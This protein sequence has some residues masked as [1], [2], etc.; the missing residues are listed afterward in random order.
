MAPR[1]ILNRCIGH[2]IRHLEHVLVVDYLKLLRYRLRCHWELW[3]VHI[4]T[5][6]NHRLSW[7]K[8]IVGIP[9]L[10]LL[11]VSIGTVALV[12]VDVGLDAYLW[13]DL[14]LGWWLSWPRW[15]SPVR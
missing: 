9:M 12:C 7:A 15:L 3:H 10:L 8:N 13:D 5:G 4:L 6:Q 11:P 2:L 14:S 1:I